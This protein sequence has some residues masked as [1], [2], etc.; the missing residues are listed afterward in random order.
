MKLHGNARTCPRSRRLLV[1]RV[2]RRDSNERS[3]ALGAWLIYYNFHRHHGSLNRQTP[4]A[5][6]S[7][8]NNVHRN[9]S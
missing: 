7:E 2:E 3:H 4:A 9:Y 5:R 8:L 1:E 6:L